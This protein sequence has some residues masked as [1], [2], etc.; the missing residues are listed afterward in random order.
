LLVSNL[1]L[2]SSDARYQKP[3]EAP[4]TD[5]ATQAAKGGD[6]SAAGTKCVK[7]GVALVAGVT[8]MLF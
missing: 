1:I 4:P 7:V 8:A 2:H 5:G 6:N 3:T